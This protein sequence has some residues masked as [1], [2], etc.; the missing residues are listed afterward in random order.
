MRK[1]LI[2][3]GFGAGWVTWCHGSRE[4]KLFMLEDAALVSLVERGEM[5]V[6]AFMARWNEVF[7]GEDP[8]HLGGMDQ[9]TVVEVD[10]EVLV[11]D[12]DGS[13]S[14]RTRGGSEWM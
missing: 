11:E 5:T 14:I 12:Y 10:G 13:E 8:P 7:P 6:G 9:L 1:I 3:P 2:S 4:Q